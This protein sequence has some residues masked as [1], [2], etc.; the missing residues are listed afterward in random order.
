MSKDTYRLAALV[1]KLVTN[2]SAFIRSQKR[3]T[4]TGGV[5]AKLCHLT[6]ASDWVLYTIRLTARRFERLR[7]TID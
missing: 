5:T 4:V 2:E 1:T 3:M 6:L 7:D